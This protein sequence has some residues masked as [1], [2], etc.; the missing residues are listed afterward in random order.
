MVLELLELVQLQEEQAVQEAVVLVLV[1]VKVV[2]LQQIKETP[3][4]QVGL[5]LA[6]AVAA[7]LDHPALAVLA[8]TA[9]MVAVA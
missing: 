9:V 4:V 2:R 8:Q 5:Q 1:K 6:E 3:A 7:V